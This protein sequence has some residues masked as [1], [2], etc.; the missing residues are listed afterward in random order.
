MAIWAGPTTRRGTMTTTTTT[1]FSSCAANFNC[2]SI[3]LSISASTV[4]IIQ[5]ND[6]R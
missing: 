1:T 6:K 3:A 5:L 2:V 4:C